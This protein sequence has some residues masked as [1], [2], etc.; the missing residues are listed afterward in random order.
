MFRVSII[1][2][3]KHFDSENVSLMQHRALHLTPCNLVPTLNGGS[4]WI[5][6]IGSL[7]SITS[8]S[9]TELGPLSSSNGGRKDLY[10]YHCYR[11]G[12]LVTAALN[13][14]RI[15]MSFLVTTLPSLWVQPSW[16]HMQKVLC[17]D[18][19]PFREWNSGVEQ[20]LVFCPLG[21][22]SLWCYS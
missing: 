8:T 10:C 5:S 13:Q 16:E 1:V 22:S 9:W 14:N 6:I 21:R 18:S 11:W 3:R 7:P 17:L 2:V 15:Q 19:R 20:H 12:N 4:N